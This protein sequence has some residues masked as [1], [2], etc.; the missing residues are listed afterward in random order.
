MPFALI[1]VGGLPVFFLLFFLIVTAGDVEAG[2]LTLQSLIDEA[3]AGSPELLA[4]QSRSGAMGYR[5]SQASSLPDPMFMFGYQ[6]EGWKRYTYGEMQGAQWMFSASQMFP[7]PGKLPIKE[8]MA[9]KDSEGAAATSQLL[10]HKT[11]ARVKELF[12]DLLVAHKNLDL[13]QERVVLFGKIEEAALARYSSGMGTQS[14]ILMAQTE[15]YM[16]RERE[17][18]LRQKIRSAEA[19]LGAVIGRDMQTPLERPAD[20]SLPVIAYD[21]ET[22]IANAYLHSPEIRTKEAMLAAAGLKVKMAEKEYYPDFTITAGYFKRAGEF[23]DMWSLTTTMNIPLFYKK[24]QRQGV[25]EAEALMSEARQELQATKLMIASAIRDNHS[26]YR[27][28]S[29]LM[30]FYKSGLIPKSYQDVEASISNYSSGKADI[31]TVISRLKSLVDIE[32]LYWN[33]YG[34]REKAA[35]KL[36]ALTAEDFR[37]TPIRTQQLQINVQEAEG[38]K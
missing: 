28:A 3:L 8:A 32:M 7:F 18:M 33:Q 31:M 9:G 22:L 11:I 15:K 27:T 16:L 26:M 1:A 23:E 20:I 30:D 6:N 10:R 38:L 24:K 25:L 2:T 13:V 37:E 19:M 35:A 21:T 17:E 5:I 29:T 36:G 12:F 34:E 14:D 4:S